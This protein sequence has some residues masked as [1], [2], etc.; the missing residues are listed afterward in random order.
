[1]TGYSESSQS[2]LDENE[3]MDFDG[4]GNYVQFDGMPDASQIKTMACRVKFDTLSTG[5]GHMILSK[6]TMGIGFEILVYN[7]Q[8]STYVMDGS[9]HCHIDYPVS[10]LSTGQW[11]HV[12]ASHNG[13][14][15]TVRLYID[16]TE[17]GNGICADI[18][19]NGGPFKVGDWF[20]GKERY[21][22]GNIADV[23]LFNTELVASEISV[24]ANG[25]SAATANQLLYA[26]L[27]ERIGDV[28]YDMSGN[29]EHGTLYGFDN[30]DSISGGTYVTKS[31]EFVYDANGNRT[32]KTE[33]KEGV[34]SSTTYTYDE[35][36][37]LIATAL[38]GTE[39]THTFAYD[40]RSRRYYRSTPTTP[41]M[42]SV[43]DGGLSIQEYET[44]SANSDLSTHMPT[45]EFIRS[46]GM[47][48]G[49]G[50]MAYSIKDDGN[51]GD[52]IISS[53]A[54][55]RGD[56]IARSNAS[57]SLTSFALY[58][59]YGT[60][61]Y[62]WGSDP[63]RQKANTKEEESDLQLLNEGMRFRDLETGTFLTRDPIGYDDGL[64]VY[65]YVL[66]NPITKFDPF[67]LA[68]VNFYAAAGIGSDADVQAAESMWADALAIRNDDGSMPEF[69]ER[70]EWILSDENPHDITVMVGA[71]GSNETTI[72][73]EGSEAAR[74]DGVGSSTNVEFDNTLKGTLAGA[75]DVER[76]PQSSLI[77]EIA[78]HAYNAAQGITQSAS[79]PHL[80]E[81]DGTRIENQH[82]AAKG[83]EQRTEY[84]MRD[85]TVVPIPTVPTETESNEPDPVV[86]EP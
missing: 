5:F 34:S 38:N 18:V 23:Q 3:G 78:G 70:M 45:T 4:V 58:E 37:R 75:G 11:Y 56:V 28:A 6:S 68:E 46:E 62:E 9:T 8:L 52:S 57:R 7:N 40:Y 13:P 22:D 50:G 25:G 86:P 73:P 49:V 1:M 17:V 14:N 74:Q 33:T 64:N 65:C 27:S 71:W 39:I 21:F 30:P 32:H 16:G 26:P 24:I 10:N 19:D 63:D 79:E 54:N 59:A 81:R 42:Y 29:E 15:S 84:V 55:H 69:V 60:R 41:H 82:R 43:F 35:D 2:E 31:V 72:P 20:Y 77:H 36:N 61:P 83:L 12:A 67:G 51:G 47:G 53:H 76:D 80:E 48:G 44:S 85:G 66:C